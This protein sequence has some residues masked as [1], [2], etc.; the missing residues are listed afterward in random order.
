VNAKH[1]VLYGNDDEQFDTD[2][3]WSGSVQWMLAIQAARSTS[4]SFGFEMSCNKGGNSGIRS[5]CPSSTAVNT[6]TIRPYSYPKISNATIIMKN[7][8]NTQ[9]L[10]LDTGTG[11]LL[12]NSIIRTTSAAS[13]CFSIQDDNTVIAQIAF[14]SVYA[15]CG[16][17]ASVSAQTGSSNVGH[18]APTV[19]QAEALWTAG[20]IGRVN[21]VTSVTL[22]T[23]LNN[24]LGTSTTLTNDFINGASENAVV[25]TDPTIL[26][27]GVNNNVGF[28]TK[29]TNIGAVSSA[30]DTWYKGWT[31]GMATGEKSCQ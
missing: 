19:A 27:D 5:M 6:G 31:C 23:V 28:F 17:I 4:G 10:K 22:P 11:L 2:N 9:A 20:N 1:L 7:T 21:S 29:P 26:N 30:S 14:R 18:T 16:G 12:M 8:A 13:N 15:I 25:V 3:T 24:Y